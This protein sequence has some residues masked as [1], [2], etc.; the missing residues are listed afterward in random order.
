MCD[1]GPSQFPETS[2][3]VTNRVIDLP[4]CFGDSLWTSTESTFR[5]LPPTIMPTLTVIKADFSR[6]SQWPQTPIPESISSLVRLSPCP[7]SRLFKD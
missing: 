6:E 7:Q 5:R 3:V 4:R 2:L 1:R